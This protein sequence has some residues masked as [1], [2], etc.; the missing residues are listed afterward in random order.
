MT[1]NLSEIEEALKDRQWLTLDAQ[2]LI[3]WILYTRELEGKLKPSDI[4]T[5]PV[6]SHTWVVDTLP[7]A[8]PGVP[9]PSTFVKP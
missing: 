4:P 5:Q 3:A 2:T 9:W 6:V 8:S 1:P 7:A